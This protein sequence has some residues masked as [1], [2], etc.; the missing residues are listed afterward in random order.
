ALRQHLERLHSHRA[1]RS[2]SRR[3]HQ[4]RPNGAHVRPRRGHLLGKR[5][6]ADVTMRVAWCFPGQG[7]QFV[8][9]GKELAERFKMAR[10]AF[11]VADEALGDKISATCFDGPES[12]LM[13]TRNTQPAILAT[14]VAALC[15]LKEIADPD[16]PVCAA[17]HSLGEYSALVASG[18]LR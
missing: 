14:S 17:G 13:L 9:M 15:A 12:E 3:A 6:G 8:G 2:R 18:S 1:R 11:E 5:A 4:A 7:S 16:V 10:A